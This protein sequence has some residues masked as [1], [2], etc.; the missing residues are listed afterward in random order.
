MVPPEPADPVVLAGSAPEF[1]WPGP[2][3]PGGGGAWGGASGATTR[4]VPAVAVTVT[5]VPLGM[6]VEAVALNSWVWPSA[7]TSTVPNRPAGIETDT[8]A[9]RPTR[10][11]VENGFV[12]SE[13]RRTV[14]I[15]NS[16][17][18]PISQP[19]VPTIA[20]GPA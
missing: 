14:N 5:G 12:P 15:T 18:N 13:R 8:D 20:A 10:L 4:P 11:D 3:A 9:V 7:L 17:P 19:I 2:G 16:M 6:S 1:D